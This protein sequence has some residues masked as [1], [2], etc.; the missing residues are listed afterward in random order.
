MSVVELS[1]L[2]LYKKYNGTHGSI[3]SEMCKRAG[4]IKYLLVYGIDNGRF[5]S[6]MRDTIEIFR[7]IL[8]KGDRK[9]AIG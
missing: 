4:T 5:Q 1:N 8:L 3:A 2:E 9:Y 7:N 6:C